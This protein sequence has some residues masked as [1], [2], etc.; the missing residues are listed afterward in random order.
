MIE[1]RL[2]LTGNANLVD[3]Y[4]QARQIIAKTHDIEAATN[5]ST[6]NVSAKKIGALANKGRP[7]TGDLRTVADTS[8]AFPKAMQSE[9]AFGEVEPLSV[10]DIAAGAASFS[11]NPSLLGAVLGRPIARGALLSGPMQRRMM[12]K[13]ANGGRSPLLQAPQL[14]ASGA[15]PYGLL[16]SGLPQQGQ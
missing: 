7:F 15:M 8:N 11:T 4:K 5:T 16:G 3:E 2:E 14:P 12:G 9:A 1:R 10:L 6:G 13:A